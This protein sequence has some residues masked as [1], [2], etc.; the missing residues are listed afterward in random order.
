MLLLYVSCGSCTEMIDRVYFQKD[1][2]TQL[3]RNVFLKVH[4][5][6]FL[7]DLTRVWKLQ[8]FLRIF[9]VKKIEGI[10]EMEHF[11]GPY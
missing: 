9:Q 5:Q 1:V 2:T 8:N 3:C 7:F 6:S 10:E 11:F 4:Y